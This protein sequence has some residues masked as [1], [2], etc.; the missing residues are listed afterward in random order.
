MSYVSYIFSKNFIGNTIEL[1]AFQAFRPRRTGANKH[2]GRFFIKIV[3]KYPLDQRWLKNFNHSVNSLASQFFTSQY[4]VSRGTSILGEV[5][6]V[7][8]SRFTQQLLCGKSHDFLAVFALAHSNC[9]IF[10][11]NYPGGFWL[12]LWYI[13]NF[14][15]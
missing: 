12:D 11:W 10:W 2:K 9:I 14:N 8:I 6:N 7:E 5:R 15:N 13:K 4:A 1:W 3:Q